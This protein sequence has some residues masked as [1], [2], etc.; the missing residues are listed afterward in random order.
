M[1]ILIG[2]QKG[3]ETN[4]E[5]SSTASDRILI[6]LSWDMD[7]LDRIKL[8]Q[9]IPFQRYICHVTDYVEDMIHAGRLYNYYRK[10]TNEHDDPNKRNVEFN[11]F[12][13]ELY[14][15]VFNNKKELIEVISPDFKQA[16]DNSETIYSTGEDF[17]GFG[18]L[19][20]EQIYIETKHMP[21]HYKHFIICVRSDCKFDLNDIKNPILR[22]ADSKTNTDFFK[23][24]IGTNDD[25]EHSALIAAHIYQKD[26]QW[27][28]KN[29]GHYDDFSIDVSAYFQDKT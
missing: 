4:F 7:E 17:T 5:V 15:Y 21:E 6:G 27:C 18:G 11:R 20:D 29:I 13:L 10:N 2:P 22:I 12:D 25:Q 8:E 3:T 14:C 1:N 19:D 24:E 9:F 26:G 28:V 16:I 23:C